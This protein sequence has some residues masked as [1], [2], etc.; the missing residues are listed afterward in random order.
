MLLERGLRRVGDC[1]SG[2][3]LASRP[4]VTRVVGEQPTNDIVRKVGVGYDRGKQV[5][6]GEMNTGVSAEP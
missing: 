1:G 3:A 4:W 2:A 6:R 5:S